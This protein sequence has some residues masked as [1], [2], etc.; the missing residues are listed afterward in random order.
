M[1]SP[2]PPY[3]D[4]T[5][6]S[7]TVMKDNAQETVY[8]YNGNARPGEMVADLTQDPPVVY[9]GNN[10]GQ[11]TQVFP[12]TSGGPVGNSGAV[13]INWLGTFSNQG[14]TPGSTYSTIQFNSDGLATINGTNAFQSS[15]NVTY[16]TINA[17]QVQSTDFGVLSGPGVTVVGYDDNYNTPRSAYFS[18]QDQA[19]VTQ[20]WDFG[21]L[22]SGSNNFSV[23]NRTADSL[24]FTVNTNG[25]VQLQVMA[26]G[27][28]PAATSA[29]LKTFVNDS[30]R[31]AS[32]NFG[33]VVGN[34]GSNV[35]PVYS[36]G[37]NWRIG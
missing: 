24:P 23:R 28:L 34:A 10:L 4:I 7:R 5:G 26:V 20:Q 19:N 3:D 1:S 35:V 25:T 16:L 22:G 14:G 36:D 9:I 12:S 17:P 33:A 11:L 30:N 37:T 31:V 21:I 27:D 2:P 13:Q 29:G 6:I 8:D 18:V 15:S 32:G